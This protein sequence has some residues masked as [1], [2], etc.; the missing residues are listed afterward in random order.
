MLSSDGLVARPRLVP[1]SR[2]LKM[3]MVWKHA[4]CRGLWFST[5]NGGIPNCLY[6]EEGMQG[7]DRYACLCA[8]TKGPSIEP[9]LIRMR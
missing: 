7:S 6:S 5:P 3:R 2:D 8:S 4:G 1:A 9:L